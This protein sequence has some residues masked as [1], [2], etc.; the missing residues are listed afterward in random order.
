MHITMSALAGCACELAQ[1]LTFAYQ[2]LPHTL[3]ELRELTTFGG[4]RTHREQP[5][6]P[7][8]RVTLDAAP[9][10]TYVRKPIE[11]LDDQ[12]QIGAT[13][14]SL[15]VH[16]FGGDGDF[17]PPCKAPGIDGMVFALAAAATAAHALAVEQCV[18]QAGLIMHAASLA[19][20]MAMLSGAE[21]F[22]GDTGFRLGDGLLCNAFWSIEQMLERA[23]KEINL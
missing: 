13:I 4:V 5:R 2:G 9:T 15:L 11:Y 21:L 19:E 17:D 20:H 6:P 7:I 1:R 22:H 23:H 18:P 16:N 3:P 8:R 10:P 14:A 12:V